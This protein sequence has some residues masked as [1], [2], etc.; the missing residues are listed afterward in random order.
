MKNDDDVI[1]TIEYK[2]YTIKIYQDDGFEYDRKDQD[3][4]GTIAAWHRRYSLGDI[5]PKDDPECYLAELLSGHSNKELDDLYS[6]DLSCLLEEFSKFFIWL[7][8]YLFDH[9]GLSMRT[10]PFGGLYGYWD[11]GQLGFIYVE[12]EKAKKE[13]GYTKLTKKRVKH[14]ESILNGEIKE[15][16][17][18]LTGNVYGFVLLDENENEIESIWGYIGDYDDYMIP[19]VKSIVD[20]LVN[21]KNKEIE[22]LNQSL[23]SDNP[24]FVGI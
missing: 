23:Y 17:D 9:S 2:Q 18:Y 7:P 5:N 11:S 13:F 19:E 24:L 12:K 3:N 16:D 21:N 4:F 8:V 22:S 15:Y 10:T 1:K 14:I 6:L 20:S